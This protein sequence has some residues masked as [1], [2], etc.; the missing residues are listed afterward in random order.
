[1][2]CRHDASY[3]VTI[4]SSA[5]TP[6]G[7]GGLRSVTG[8]V[9]PRARGLLMLAVTVV[10]AGLIVLFRWPYESL[11][12]SLV[13]VASGVLGGVLLVLLGVERIRMWLRWLPGARGRT[14]NL[15]L[16]AWVLLV[17]T[18]VVT[19]L[20]R[21]ADATVLEVSA[22]FSL[23][24]YRPLVGRG[25]LRGLDG[26]LPVKAIMGAVYVSWFVFSVMFVMTGGWV[27]GGSLLGGLILS[28]FAG[29]WG[30]SGLGRALKFALYLFPLLTAIAVRNVIGVTG[31][32]ALFCYAILTD[33][34]LGA[35]L[36]DSMHR[37]RAV[38]EC[39][40]PNNS[41]AT[42]TELLSAYKWA[43][44]RFDTN[45]VDSRELLP[46]VVRVRRG[47]R[48][49]VRICRLRWP[50]RMSTTGHLRFVLKRLKDYDAS[51]VAGDSRRLARDEID[52]I[53]SFLDLIGAKRKLGWRGPLLAAVVFVVAIGFVVVVSP[54][55]LPFV[56]IRPVL[57]ILIDAL[58]SLTNSKPNDVFGAIPERAVAAGGIG[59]LLATAAALL[60]AIWLV[61]ALPA[62]GYRLKH[63]LFVVYPHDEDLRVGRAIDQPSSAEG[64]Y[65]IERSVFARLGWKT[66]PPPVFD[67]VYS[68][69]TAVVLPALWLAIAYSHAA[70]DAGLYGQSG[71]NWAIAYPWTFF[72]ILAI[73][74]ILGQ[75]HRRR[76]RRHISTESLIRLRPS[77]L[78]RSPGS[79]GND[80]PV[81]TTN[82]VG[83]A[84]QIASQEVAT[85]VD[86]SVA[87][88]AIGPGLKATQFVRYRRSKAKILDDALF[89]ALDDALCSAGQPADDAGANASLA[90]RNLLEQLKVTD[91]PR[92]GQI[93]TRRA[94]TK[95]WARE[96]LTIRFPSL[97]VT[98]KA[99]DPR[100]RQWVADA[101]RSERGQK[102]LH[103]AGLKPVI[104]DD[105]AQ[106]IA[107]LVPAAFRRHVERF[108]YKSDFDDKV[109]AGFL[110][111]LWAL[112]NSPQATL[113]RKPAQ[114]AA[115]ATI[116]GV[117]TGVATTVV[118][119]LTTNLQPVTSFG[120]GAA[121]FV[122][123]T[124]GTGILL[125]RTPL[126]SPQFETR[127][128]VLGWLSEL[129]ERLYDLRS[130]AVTV[131]E[132]RVSLERAVGRFEE[133][134]GRRPP[135]D[136]VVSVGDTSPI[137]AD[138]DRLQE[139]IRLADTVEDSEVLAA[140]I[141]LD[142]QAWSSRSRYALF[143]PIRRLLGAL[144]S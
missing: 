8:R 109:R 89:H 116:A 26:S 115:N 135:D 22:G 49:P 101:L 50:A 16:L 78:D 83:D 105:D 73:L 41:A 80:Q 97:D 84:S 123:V 130:D 72:A 24:A 23:V 15:V 81:D 76:S 139:L 138:R 102:A 118:T 31:S 108:N 20:R 32:T 127:R 79:N 96:F 85:V 107:N 112:D 91:L 9:S 77:T 134:F 90:A 19:V 88:K 35:R 117:L 126:T 69:A 62:S 68:I 1:M 56:D 74:A 124:L 111:D 103:D 144:S 64:I 57:G 129:I 33:N 43:W 51:L 66:P 140:L 3:T 27:I 21:Q 106:R 45:L 100:L 60:V 28:T 121:V 7:M 137:K 2:H 131:P 113:D 82:K 40:V 125:R 6:R 5:T 143:E 13:A 132:V 44:R 141:A 128:A 34:P 58:S 71:P 12:G 110:R 63:L 94:R 98:F 25:D 61:C 59:V 18:V 93:R 48:W 46:P 120:T 136:G 17:G 133:K 55:G 95:R 14:R 29:R 119:D 99:F 86:P 114:A 87:S 37:R 47:P 42:V 39:S 70:S 104:D 10:L 30:R 54:I 65:R 53:K 67:L 142:T 38:E 4:K 122:L 36:Q 75:L 11:T 52:E 92:E